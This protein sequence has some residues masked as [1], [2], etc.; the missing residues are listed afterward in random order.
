MAIKTLHITNPYHPTSGGIRTFYNA[1]L[2]AANHHRRPVRLVVPSAKTSVQEVGDFGRIY[3]IASPRAPVIDSRYRW[4][5]P[6]TYAWPYDS[7]LRRILAT[8]RPDLIEVCD[9]FWLLYLSGV[10]RR[11]W[12]PGVPVPVIVGL[13]CERL[14]DNM[15]TYV[16]ASRAARYVCVRYVRQCYVPRFD[17]HIA[18]SD[19]IATEVRQLLPE[20]MRGRLHVC[21]MGVD[22]AAL[23]QT[24]QTSALRHELLVQM[25]GNT[26]TIPLLYAGRLAKEKNLGILPSVL[27]ELASVPRPDYRLLVA[28]EGPL[29]GE[30]R[31]SLERVAPGRSL[32]LGHCSAEEL[33]ALYRA[34]DIFIHPNP[35]EPFGIAPLEAMPAGLPLVAPAS[36]GVLTYANR[37]NAWLAQDTPRSFAQAVQQVHSDPAVR[38]RKIAEA[39]RAAE[40]LSWPRITANYFQLYDHFHQ[41]SV[42]QGLRD[43]PPLSLTFRRPLPPRSVPSRSPDPLC[44]PYQLR[45]A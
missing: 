32:F 38:D 19:Y 20:R 39:R 9:K 28:G 14:D 27:A 24:R 1:L 10:L 12:I 26:S 5:L 16:S 25:A 21:P 45:P 4:M 41:V 29:S 36:G 22:F 2:N 18:A 43:Q 3:H 11:R 33:A 40:K 37:E 13:T 17:F 31:R 8:E 7:S 44:V 23:N 6:H 30:L 35:R 34:A 42:H 15:A